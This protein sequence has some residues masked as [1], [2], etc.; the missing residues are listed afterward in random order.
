MQGSYLVL[1]LGPTAEKSSSPFALVWR[2]YGKA[3]KRWA[4]RDPTVIS[5]EILTVVL[6]GPA[7]AA[8][9]YAIAKCVA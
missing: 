5:L 6:G 4:V 1:A 7:A 2:E 3:D 9:L 8:M